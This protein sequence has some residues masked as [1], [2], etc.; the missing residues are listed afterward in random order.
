VKLHNNGS[1][2]A[3]AV[4]MMA[5][6]TK[7]H[8]PMTIRRITE[9]RGTFRVTYETVTAESAEQGD[10]ADCG[11]LSWN[12]CS[13]EDY[14]ESCWDLHDLLD[15]LAGCYAEGDGA[16]VPSWLSFDP[17]SDFWLSPFWR[18]LAGEDALGVTASVHRPDWITDSSWIRVCRLLGWREP[19]LRSAN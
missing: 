9:P 3:G 7:G 5:E 12:G 13:C 6:S 10:Y 18:D 1:E 4:A 19:R 16:A 14:E 2:A 15:R 8:H 17:Q 11:W